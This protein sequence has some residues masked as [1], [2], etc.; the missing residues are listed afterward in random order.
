MFFV[1]IEEEERDEELDFGFAKIR[2]YSSF[3]KEEEVLF[4]PLN[5]FR[6]EKV[7]KRIIASKSKY[8]DDR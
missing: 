2:E 4:N 5:T 1:Q 8:E 7:D 6:I 3:P